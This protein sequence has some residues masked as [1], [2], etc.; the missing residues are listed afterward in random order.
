MSQ[1]PESV[2]QEGPFEKSWHFFFLEKEKF[3][4]HQNEEKLFRIHKVWMFDDDDD[5]DE[6]TCG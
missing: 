5:D 2:A 1:Y 4:G 3:Y 6:K